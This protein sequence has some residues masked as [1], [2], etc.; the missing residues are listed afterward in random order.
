M[1]T[2][3]DLPPSEWSIDYFSQAPEGEGKWASVA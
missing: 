1:V 3:R 2:D